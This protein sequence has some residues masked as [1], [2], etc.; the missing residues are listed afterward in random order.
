MTAETLSRT[1]HNP[2]GAY[3]PYMAIGL[4]ISTAVATRQQAMPV[5]FFVIVTM[6]FLG[7][8]FTPVQSMPPWAQ[9]LAEA[10]LIKHFVGV[11]R[12]VLI[13]GTRRD[14][15]ASHAPPSLL[16]MLRSL[17]TLTLLVLSPAAL[18][19]CETE[20]QREVEADGEVDTDVEV[21]VEDDVERDV[22][23]G[24]REAAADAGQALEEAGEEIREAAGD[25]H[26][27]IDSNVDLGD[28]AEN[29]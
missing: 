10:N 13:Q 19:G 6:F 11:L 24:A 22:E 16:A 3:L 18:T 29:Q 25:V 8:V 28:N 14:G 2:E 20:T 12:D 27:A 26:D 17:L 7:G 1:L 21:G 4:L 23:A 15:P 5:T 9:A